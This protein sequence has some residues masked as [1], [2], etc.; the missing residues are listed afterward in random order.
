MR[1]NL[2]NIRSKLTF[3]Q[4]QST[5]VHKLIDLVQSDDWETKPLVQ[6]LITSMI[7]NTC[8]NTSLYTNEEKDFW[9]DMYNSVPHSKFENTSADMNGLWRS[10]VCSRMGKQN[11]PE[12]GLST[13]H[14]TDI[15]TAQNSTLSVKTLKKL[16]AEN[17]SLSEIDL[18][19]TIKIPWSASDHA[20]D[21]CETQMF[22]I[23]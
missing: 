9:I 10:T 12:F 19:D 23:V 18:Y 17:I 1:L 14:V 11:T 4:D 5:V 13:S 15:A 2:E 6:G 21:L 16:K 22:S 3:Y 20:I 8:R 7:T